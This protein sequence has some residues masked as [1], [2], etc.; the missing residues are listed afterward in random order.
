MD[1]KRLKEVYQRYTKS[2]KE[3]DSNI[4]KNYSAMSSFLNDQ[5]DDEEVKMILGFGIVSK[6]IKAAEKRE[7]NYFNHSKG[8]WDSND[9]KLVHK[10]VKAIGRANVTGD[11]EVLKLHLLELFRLFAKAKPMPALY[12]YLCYYYSKFELGKNFFVF[13]E[14]LADQLI[15]D[16]S[17]R[18]TEQTNSSEVEPA[19]KQANT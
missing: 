11:K 6:T 13:H 3:E 15:G 4:I 9:V 7:L 8:Q 19:Q 10:L 18:V 12:L 16:L 1:Y 17:D 14:Q 5:C 2:L